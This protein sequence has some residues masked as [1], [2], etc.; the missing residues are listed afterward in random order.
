MTSH[1]IAGR[2]NSVASPSFLAGTAAPSLP[3]TA[4]SATKP[5]REATQSLAICA[6]D[7]GPGPAATTATRKAFRPEA[8]LNITANH[9]YCSVPDVGQDD[10]SLSTGQHRTKSYTGPVQRSLQEENR[11][12]D[13]QVQCRRLMGR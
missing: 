5:T 2:E 12:G 7:T 9:L 3:K 1:R 11:H 6:N 4:Q 8:E 13:A 10:G